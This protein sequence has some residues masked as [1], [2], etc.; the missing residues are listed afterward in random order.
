MSG[1]IQEMEQQKDD[2]NEVEE[3]DEVNDNVLWGC[4]NHHLKSCAI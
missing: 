4:I 2:A 3:D 1:T